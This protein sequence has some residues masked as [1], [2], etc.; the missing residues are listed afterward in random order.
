MSYYDKI[1]VPVEADGVPTRLSYQKLNVLCQ[2]TY[3]GQK[4][5]SYVGPLLGNNLNKTI[6]TSTSLIAFKQNII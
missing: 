5:L 6:K 4:A 3:I 2:K 1:S